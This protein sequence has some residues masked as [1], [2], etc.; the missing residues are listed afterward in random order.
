MELNQAQRLKRRADELKMRL[1]GID[2]W[3]KATTARLSKTPKAK[4]YDSRIAKLVAAKLD[5]ETELSAIEE[6]LTDAQISLSVEIA[7]LVKLTALE[8]QVLIRRYSLLEDFAAIATAL[9]ISQSHCY[10]LHRDGVK[11]FKAGEENV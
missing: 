2:D 11:K 7:D 3:L 6:Q 10:K 9:F 1:A 4:N 5:C 8:K